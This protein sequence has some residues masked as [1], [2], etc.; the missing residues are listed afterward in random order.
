MPFT[1]EI[2]DP[3]SLP[4]L[5]VDDSV[6]VSRHNYILQPLG[7][8]VDDQQQ[9]SGGDCHDLFTPEDDHP[10]ERWRPEEGMNS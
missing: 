10:F 1:I 4:L 7:P 3:I 6:L 2:F 5:W 9:T 8:Q